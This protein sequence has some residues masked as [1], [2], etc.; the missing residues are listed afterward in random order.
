MIGRMRMQKLP[1]TLLVD[2]QEYYTGDLYMDLIPKHVAVIMDGNGRWATAKNKIRTF[3]HQAGA[4]T[5]K[6][7]VRTAQKMGV[8]AMTAYA[9]STENWKRP[10]LE[11]EILMTLLNKYLTDEIEELNQNNVR[12][13]FSG[14]ETTLPSKL[15]QKMQN[16]LKKTENNTGLILNLAINYG[17]RAEI[18][19]ATKAF[20]TDVAEGRRNIED[21]TEQSFGG[22]LYT[23]GLPEIDL[24]IRSG[25]DVRISNFLLW[26]IAYA[27]IWLTPTFWPDFTPEL[28]ITA[29][30]DFQKRDRRF[31][32]LK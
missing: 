22:Y 15:Q 5:L 14:D 32:G 25:G 2:A 21:L 12:I 30:R 4:E 19:R 10:K 24:L 11:V 7:I 20:A 6:T 8:Q 16:A 28:F 3:G 27:E 1:N 31:G 18:V 17:S 23:A 26:Q 29:V 9:F 13:I